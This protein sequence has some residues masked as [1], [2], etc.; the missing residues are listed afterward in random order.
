M[1]AKKSL[2]QNFLKSKQALSAISDAGE[3]KEG[4]LVIEIGPGKGALT[5]YLLEKTSRVV[6]IEKDRELIEFLNEKFQEEVSGG[7]LTIIEG[8]I[9]DFDEKTIEK[10]YKLIANIPYYIT[11]EIM[12]KFLSSSNQP[13]RVVF[14]LQKEVVDRIMVRDGKES[15]LSMSVKAFGEPKYI[16]KVQ[17][18]AFSPAPKVDSAILAIGGISK[19]R[20]KGISE[21]KFFRVLKTGFAH[22]RKMLINN[23]EKLASKEDLVNLFRKLG[24]EAK[25]RAETLSVD[26]WIELS[27]E[28]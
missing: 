16:Q 21:D 5:K 12:E 11:G 3:I 20:F 6:A 23:L 17:A 28:L 27:K 13:E 10:P 15:I 26:N 25:T 7:A 2:G 4:E 24:L 14:L 1:R 18:K 9:L 22:K 19:S 8:D